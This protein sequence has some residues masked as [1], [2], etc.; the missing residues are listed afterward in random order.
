MKKN[1]TKKGDVK[2]VA[3]T[4]K[5]VPPKSEKK[6]GTLPLGKHSKQTRAMFILN[7]LIQNRKEKLP[8]AA[9]LAK[10]QKEF[11]TDLVPGP[12]GTFTIAH[13]RGVA[14]KDRVLGRRGLK[15]TDAEFVGYD[16]KE[17]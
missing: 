16:E 1:G 15:K 4:P 11:S 14:N 2:K 3:A 5:S 7:L 13:Q 6:A 9:L 12:S 10:A 8:D 17:V